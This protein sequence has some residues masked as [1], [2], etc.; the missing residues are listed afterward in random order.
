MSGFLQHLRVRMAAVVRS[1]F[2]LLMVTVLG[3]VSLMMYPIFRSDP[4]TDM[5]GGLQFLI[6]ALMIWLFLSAGSWL[7][8][9]F[10]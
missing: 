5:E 2:A 4:L 8:A 9:K 10:V 6:R 7:M 1:P 3:L